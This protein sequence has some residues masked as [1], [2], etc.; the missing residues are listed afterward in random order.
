MVNA[1]PTGKASLHAV[2]ARALVLVALVALPQAARSE[3]AASGRRVTR[4]SAIR[5][6]G[7]A[8]GASNRSVG[9]DDSSVPS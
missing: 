8:L 9:R 7:D 2:A 1:F 6:I 4:G 5:E 3:S